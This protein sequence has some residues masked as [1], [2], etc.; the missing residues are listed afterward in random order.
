MQLVKGDANLDVRAVQALMGHRSIRTTEIY[1]RKQQS[2]Q[3]C[4]SLF[5]GKSHG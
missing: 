2:E 3:L 4:L 1:L 5:S